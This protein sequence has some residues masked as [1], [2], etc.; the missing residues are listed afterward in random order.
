VRRSIPSFGYLEHF[1]ADF[2]RERLVD[3]LPAQIETPRREGRGEGR[4]SDEMKVTSDEGKRRG[5]L[6]TEDTEGTEKN[7]SGPRIG[8]IRTNSELGNH[9]EG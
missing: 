1:L 5:G 6:T 3:T 4:N 8:S 9:A 7:K 2:R